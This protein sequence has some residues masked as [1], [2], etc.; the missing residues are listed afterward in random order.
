[1]QRCVKLI[2]T[3][4]FQVGFLGIC[5]EKLPVLRGPNK[6]GRDP[7]TCGIILNRNVSILI[8]LEMGVSESFHE[9]T[10][11]TSGNIRKTGMFPNGRYIHLKDFQITTVKVVYTNE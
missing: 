7:Q 10:R 6:I 4:C 1:M 9:S 5:G 2:V 11:Y 8:G 3:K